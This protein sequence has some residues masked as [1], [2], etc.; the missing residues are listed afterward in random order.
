MAEAD[1]VNAPRVLVKACG[2]VKRYGARLAVDA[3]DLEVHAGEIYGLIGPDGAGKSSLLKAIAGVLSYDQGSLRVFDTQLDSERAAE[4]V[5]D[6]IGLMPQRL[7]QNLYGDLSVEENIDYFAG[8]RGIG[9]AELKARKDNLLRSTRLE[10]FR[11]RAMKNLSGG[12]KQKLGLVCTLIHEP[13]LLILD[14]PTTGIDPVSRREFWT[15]LNRLLKQKEI[16][17]LVSTA[18]MNEASQFHRLSLIHDGKIIASGKPEQIRRMA[19]GC[20]VRTVAENQVEALD[21][22]AA[23]FGQVEAFGASVRV[24]VADNDQQQAQAKVEAALNDIRHDACEAIEPE[25]E[26]VF[27]ALLRSTCERTCAQPENPAAREDA[28]TDQANGFAGDGIAIEADNLTRWFGKFRAVE[29]VSFQIPKGQI[30]G[31]L[32]ANGA[33]KSTVI[34]MLIGIL[35]PNQGRG[36]V[37]GVDMRSAGRLIRERIG[38]M[39]QAFSLYLDLTVAEN[40][41]LYAGIYGLRPD[42]TRARIDSTLEIA[43]LRTFSGELC[44]S[45]PIG[46]RQRL[47]LGCALIHRPRVL[48]LDE[49]TSGVDPLGRRAFWEALFHLSRVENVTILVTTHYMAEAERCDHVALMHAGRIVAAASQDRLKADVESEIGQPFELQTDQPLPVLDVL[50]AIGFPSST[51]FGPNIHL[52]AP[53][54][55]QDL[56]RIRAALGARGLNLKQAA[57]RRLSMEDAF[58]HIVTKLEGGAEVRKPERQS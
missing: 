15:F 26:D 10:N 39:S 41:R 7:G 14:E 56:Q 47:A 20:I 5:K 19:P 48:F 8:L 54:P 57:R 45:L 50:H 46:L 49:P 51:L 9:G 22:L 4:R 32:G 33:G 3:V 38:Y 28:A 30:F 31:L 29:Q 16:T 1:L 37:A 35:A 25:L 44:A 53:A 27:V 55:E 23:E 58:V 34:K 40:I 24:F 52:F 2:I 36:R 43:G 13:R 18:Y 6:Q 42:Q 12:M 17:A 11:D 21:R